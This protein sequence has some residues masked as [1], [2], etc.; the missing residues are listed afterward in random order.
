MLLT[1]K[2]LVCSLGIELKKITCE[3][4]EPLAPRKISSKR[5][6]KQKSWKAGFTCLGLS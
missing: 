4:E 5:V 3:S 6:K 2:F 1:V